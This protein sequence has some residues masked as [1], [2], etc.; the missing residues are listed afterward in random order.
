[1]LGENQR[2]SYS[3]KILAKA[4][5]IETGDTQNNLLNGALDRQNVE[6]IEALTR[7]KSLSV[8]KELKGKRKFNLIRDF[9]YVV[10]YLV[11]LEFTGLQEVKR[12]PLLVRFFAPIRNIILCSYG[13][14]RLRFWTRNGSADSFLLW[15]ATM[16]GQIF[17]N[18]GN[19]N[20]GLRLAASWGASGYYKNIER[21]LEESDSA[22]KYS[23]LKR[24]IKVSNEF[25]LEE[26]VGSNN[27]EVTPEEYRH[28]IV[29]LLLEVM[30]SFHILIGISFA[31][32]W[33]PILENEGGLESFIEKLK[34]SNTDEVINHVLSRNS[35]TAMLYRVARVPF[36]EFGIKSGDYV[37]F[38]IR[39]ASR[40][41]Q[42][43]D[44][45]LNFGPHEKCP[46]SLLATGERRY[47]EETSEK[48]LHPCFGQF[49]ARTVLKTMF[50]TLVE[51]I[52]EIKP[53]KNNV[54]E[55]GIPEILMVTTKRK[56]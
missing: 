13:A 6:A 43:K 56:T 2:Q 51:E 16:F 38:R 36:P 11:G 30:T 5:S 3:W 10:P 49:W 17:G 54:K 33:K 14:D 25:I 37:C 35:T 18:P 40:H 32:M 7:Q 41:V 42:N 19:F 31:N 21:S 9:G 39:E 8:L 26:G 47:S 28:M 48:A 27:S 50:L 53:T 4:L 15:T 46:Y 29:C 24:L 23:L 45:W 22:P 1:M 34:G 52:P 12:T 20:N 44:E 55:L